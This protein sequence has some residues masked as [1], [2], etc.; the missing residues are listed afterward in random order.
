MTDEEMKDQ[1]AV[2]GTG[3]SARDQRVEDELASINQT[4][5]VLLNKVDLSSQVRQNSSSQT[6]VE[7]ELFNADD[8]KL[9]K[10]LRERSASKG[11]DSDSS[12]N[13]HISDSVASSQT[14]SLPRNSPIALQ[15]ARFIAQRI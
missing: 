14:C 4:L 11:E 12:F 13:E 6:E 2:S 7:S 5:G 15:S 3:S 10:K 9:Q 1:L 8:S